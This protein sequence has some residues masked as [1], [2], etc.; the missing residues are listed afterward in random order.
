M[1]ISDTKFAIMGLVAISGLA[2][3]VMIV[4]GLGNEQIDMVFG[5]CVGAIAGIVSK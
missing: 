4:T 5:L 3:G 2:T 1:N